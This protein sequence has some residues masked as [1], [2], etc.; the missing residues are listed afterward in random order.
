MKRGSPMRAIPV[1]SVE[2]QTMLA[3]HR[4]RENRRD[5]RTALLNQLRG[6]LA[7]YGVVLK[8][9]REAGLADAKGAMKPG[10]TIEIEHLRRL[11]IRGAKSRYG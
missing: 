3:L 7:E 9:G 11:L 2:Q 10:T 1:K 8:R 5:M 6:L 4:V